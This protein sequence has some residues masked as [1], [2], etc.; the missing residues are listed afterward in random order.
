MADEGVATL[1]AEL[2]DGPLSER[3]LRKAAGLTHRAAHERLARLAAVGVVHAK[4]GSPSGRGRP[5]QRWQ[6]SH[7][8]RLARFAEQAEAAARALRSDT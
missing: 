8:D 6:L 7:A 2:G 4:P 5:A 1:V 3:E